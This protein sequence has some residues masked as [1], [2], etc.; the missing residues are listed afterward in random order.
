MRVKDVLATKGD[1]VATIDPE[2][3]VGAAISALTGHRVGALVV[4]TDGRSI[5]GIISE[6]DIV[7][8]LD[9]VGVEILTVP[10][11]TLMTA[12][13]QTCSLTDEIRLLATTMTQ[14][15]FR[16]LPVVADGV[17]A[18]IVSIGDIVKIRVDELETEQQQLMGYISSAG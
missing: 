1:A 17:L 16:H 2:A 6:R 11:R 14:G 18:G 10:V 5:D 3:T 4:T 15:R 8:G 13:V 7:H 9:S 12:D